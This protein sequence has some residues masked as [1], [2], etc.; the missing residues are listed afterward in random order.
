MLSGDFNSPP[1][2]RPTGTVITWGQGI[3]TKG[4]TVIR[5]RIRSR[6]GVRWN[7]AECHVLR[8]LPADDR[9]EVYRML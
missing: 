5:K 4:V 1:R 2:E 6:E 8:A 3:N 9:Q 7:R